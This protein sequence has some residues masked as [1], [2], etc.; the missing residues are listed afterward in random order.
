MATG[1]F[2]RPGG[3]LPKESWVEL[4]GCRLVHDY[5]PA[6]IFWSCCGTVVGGSNK[7]EMYSIFRVSVLPSICSNVK[8]S[9]SGHTPNRCQKV[10]KNSRDIYIYIT[11]YTSTHSGSPSYWPPSS[12]PSSTLGWPGIKPSLRRQSKKAWGNSKSLGPMRWVTLDG[13]VVVHK[14]AT[15]LGSI[16]TWWCE[17]WDFNLRL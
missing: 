1:V 6:G 13:V 16:P 9:L 15:S 17:M 11:F 14:K 7:F 2:G 8:R 10:H 3:R 5:L 12:Y 4:L